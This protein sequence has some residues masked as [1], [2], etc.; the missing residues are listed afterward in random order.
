M[1]ITSFKLRL[2]FFLTTLLN[3]PVTATAQ[4]A[5]PLP[6][7]SGY[8]INQSFDFNF[9][10]NH[11]GS[12]QLLQDERITPA[13][14]EKGGA[15]DDPVASLDDEDPLKQDLVKTPLRPSRLRLIDSDGHVL[16]EEDLKAPLAKIDT[17]DLYG[18]KLTTYLVSVDHDVGAGSYTGIETML[19]EIKDNKLTHMQTDEGAQEGKDRLWLLKSLKSDWRIVPAPFG[20]AKEIQ[21]VLCR[22]NWGD[23]TNDFVVVYNTYHFAHKKWHRE[24]RKVTGF[25]EAE[26]DWPPRSSFPAAPH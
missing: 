7:P 3:V 25:W 13:L 26:G 1:K 4:E 22:P 9:E 19:V 18:S 15:S 17:A 6:V 23:K 5:L 24:S 11:R 20:K 2:A 14:Q 16:D 10:K 21:Q 8:V 12:L